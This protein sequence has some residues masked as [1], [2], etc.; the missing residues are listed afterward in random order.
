[1]A[2][3]VATSGG[4]SGKTNSKQDGAPAPTPRKKASEK[5]QAPDAE[6]CT[7]PPKTARKKA[8]G[9]Q[10]GAVEID[11]DTLRKATRLSMLGGLQNLTGRPELQGKG[12]SAAS[13]LEA[14]KKTDGLV[15]AAKHLLL[16]T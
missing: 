4:N 11:A 5:A 7:T 15:N 2:A 8:Q 12:F 10:A 6:I 16:G 14:L 9:S 3:D 13:L 1:M